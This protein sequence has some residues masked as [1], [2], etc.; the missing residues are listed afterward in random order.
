[1]HANAAPGVKQA[2]AG[3]DG[4]VQQVDA[5]GA[6]PCIALAGSVIVAHGRRRPGIAGVVGQ[7]INERGDVAQREVQP[8]RPDGRQ[9]V[10]AFTHERDPVG[11]ECVGKQSFDGK[12]PAGQDTGN[13]AEMMG[14]RLRKRGGKLGIW[15]GQQT[16]GELR[17]FHPHIAGGVAQPR[18][19]VLHL[20]RWDKDE[21]AG[22]AVELGRN[23][24][25]R[26]RVGN[27]AGDSPLGIRPAPRRDARSLA[28]HGIAP[29]RS[30]HQVCRNRV[31]GDSNVHSVFVGPDGRGAL[32]IP[33][34][35]RGC[36][37]QGAQPINERG[38][39]HVSPKQRT[40]QVVRGK[41]DVRRAPK[42]GREINDGQALQGRTAAQPGG[43]DP[44]PGQQVQG[45]FK[46]RRGARVARVAPLWPDQCSV[47][48]SVGERH[49]GA[50]CGRPSANNGD[51]MT[52]H[53]DPFAWV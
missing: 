43:V 37:E 25:M 39:G 26:P 8:L 6:Q 4:A 53:A 46:Q 42:P 34:R 3:K 11:C 24:A 36:R 49:G 1:L 35:R 15:R 16:G 41:R 5:D 13:G 20:H 10:R 18:V 12:A 47:E 40:I 32:G 14:A 44:Q 33:G 52:F 9:H 28:G 2:K 7:H 31:P 30:D 45:G 17:L 38:I 19:F 21:R 48:P 27:G 23:V 29:V 22:I 50:Q 51:L